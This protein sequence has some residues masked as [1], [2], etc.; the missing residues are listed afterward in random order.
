MNR[1]TDWEEPYGMLTFTSDKDLNLKVLQFF[2]DEPDLKFR[3]MTDLCGVHYPDNN[4]KG[5]W[6]LFII[7]IIWLIMS[8]SGLKYLLILKSRMF[9]VLRPYFQQ[10]TGWK[11]KPMIFMELILLGILI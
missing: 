6:Q 10:Q 1:L 8:G 3:F 2:Y 9:S 7:C 11:E 5:N 4:R